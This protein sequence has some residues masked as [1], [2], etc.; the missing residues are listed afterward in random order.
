MKR[1]SGPNPIAQA[2]RLLEEDKNEIHLVFESIFRSSQ[3]HALVP[4]QHALI[5]PFPSLD[6]LTR[7]ADTH[8]FNCPRSLHTEQERLR[9]ARR[10]WITAFT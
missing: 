7:K 5:L 1:L 10:S 3:A 8:S 6:L 2:Q 4:A 9:D